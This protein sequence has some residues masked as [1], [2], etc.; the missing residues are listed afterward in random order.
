MHTFAVVIPFSVGLLFSQCS[1]AIAETTSDIAFRLNA[2]V[3]KV[4]VGNEKGDRGIGSG[5]V[6]SPDNVVTNCHVVANA[7]GIAV[8]KN[9][10]NY[11]PVALKADWHHDLCILKFDGLPVPA[12]PLGDGLPLVYEQDVF[13]I[14]YPGNPMKP[15]TAFG[16]IKGLYTLDDAQVIR[17]SAAFRMG[18][19]GGA[20]F[21]E[22]G[23][24]IG[25][26][27]FKS[28]GRLS[29]YYS[30]PVVW[31]KRLIDQPEVSITRQAELPFWDAPEEKRPFFMQVVNDQLVRNW[32]ELEQIANKWITV[33]PGSS[34][35]WY[36]L[37][38]SE[39]KQGK[40]EQAIAAYRKS[41]ELNP[42]HTAALSNWG[43][44]ALRAGNHSEVERIGAVLANIDPEAGDDFKLALTQAA[45]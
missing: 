43:L 9:G 20:L 19:S 13:S 24:L 17:T 7:H 10:E 5:V 31:V 40:A 37:G 38:V 39:E 42:R 12:V 11:L 28:P 1:P 6:V 44:L 4:Q 8:T 29:N 26:N 25:I 45:Q 15:L 2:S 18:A 30:L 36:Y 21:D 14:G 16:K 23:R 32:T 41:V 3:V 35:A 27:T 34:E 33:E 22:E